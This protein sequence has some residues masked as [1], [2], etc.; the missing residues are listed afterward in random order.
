MRFDP[1]TIARRRRAMLERG[2]TL[3]SLLSDVLAGARPPALEALLAQKPGERP[4]EM[5]R[6]ALDQVEAR[7]LLLDAGDDRYGRCG[8]CGVELGA[9]GLDE[10]PWADRC[11]THM[12]I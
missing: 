12:T 6:R 9:V 2:R 4:A 8:V 3:A 10:L 11:A 5:L 1:E 7:R